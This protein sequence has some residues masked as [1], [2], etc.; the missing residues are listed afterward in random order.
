LNAYLAEQHTPVETLIVAAPESH[1]IASG[2]DQAG[3]EGMNQ[4]TGQGSHQGGYSEAA[5]NP[6]QN[7]QAAT[8]ETAAPAGRQETNAPP[9]GVGGRHISVM[10]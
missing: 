3:S 4:E 2:M 5:A 6:R 9:V 1:G 10:A 7:T 8:A